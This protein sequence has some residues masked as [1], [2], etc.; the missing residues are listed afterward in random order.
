MLR[1]YTDWWRQVSGSRAGSCARGFLHKE[2][3]LCPTQ[4][5]R[6]SQSQLTIFAE[7]SIQEP[8]YNALHLGQPAAAH[9][10]VCVLLRPTRA[11][12]V[13]QKKQQPACLHMVSS[14]RQR[15]AHKQ[16]GP[17]EPH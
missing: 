16:V 2:G 8:F 12:A 6:P 15:A 5:I 10:T 7:P 3:C 11:G 9:T 17:D 13:D 14:V 1:V 4:L